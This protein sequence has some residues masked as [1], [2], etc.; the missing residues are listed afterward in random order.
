MSVKNIGRIIKETVKCIALSTDSEF[1][2]YKVTSR[3]VKG[4]DLVILGNGPSLQKCMDEIK[5]YRNCD[6]LTVNLFPIKS[7]D[8]LKLNRNTIV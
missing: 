8:F 4:R 5:S 6:Y 3:N 7:E 1:R 2:K